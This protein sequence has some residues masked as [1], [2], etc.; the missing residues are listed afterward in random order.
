MRGDRAEPSL[1]AAA[2]GV[3]ADAVIGLTPLS[4]PKGAAVVAAVLPSKTA[5]IVKVRLSLRIARS[6]S[7]TSSGE[8]IASSSDRATIFAHFF[9]ASAS[10]PKVNLE[11]GIAA[12]SATNPPVAVGL[13]VG[14]RIE[15]P[16]TAIVYSL[17]RAR[18]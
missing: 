1:S 9:G 18:N 8:L 12:P 15:V 14:T 11:T 5:S 4:K 6:V 13:Q 10:D 2:A 3:A 7:S 17:P 16:L